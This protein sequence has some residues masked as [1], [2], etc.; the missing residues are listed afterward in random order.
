V[1]QQFNLIG[2]LKVEDNLAFQARLAGR[3]RAAAGRRI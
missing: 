2:S 3:H 1:F